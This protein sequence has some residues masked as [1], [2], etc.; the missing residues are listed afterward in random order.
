MITGL[1]ARMAQRTAS[2]AVSKQSAGVAGAITGTGLSPL[3][4]KRFRDGLR[5]V[6]KTSRTAC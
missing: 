3:R 6:M 1:M 5:T 4:P 2:T